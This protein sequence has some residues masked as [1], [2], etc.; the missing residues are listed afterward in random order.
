VKAELQAEILRAI[1]DGYTNFISGFAEGV[2]LLFAR[3]CGG[4]D[5]E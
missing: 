3:H 1:G 5:E 4:L 2:D